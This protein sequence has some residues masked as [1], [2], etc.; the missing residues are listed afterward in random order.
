MQSTDIPLKLPL[1]FAASAGAGYTRVIPTA[2][3]IGVVNGQASLTDG[4]V[5]LNATPIASGGVPPDIKDMN[6]ILFEISG[7]SRWQAAG[8][9]VFYDSAFATAIGGYPKG[10]VLQSATTIGLL[11]VSTAEANT[12]NPDAGGANWTGLVSAPATQAMVNAGVN[13]AAFVT[14]ATLAGLRA[15]SAD[16]IAGTDPAKYMTPQAFYGARA[17]GA[18]VA[19]GVNDH[20]YITPAGLA[21]SNSQGIVRLPGGLVMQY[22]QDNV[23]RAEGLQSMAFN[24]PFAIAVDSVIVCAINDAGGTSGYYDLWVQWDRAGTTLSTF[25]FVVQAP[26]SNTGNIAGTSWVAF[27]R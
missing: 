14:P 1:P 15:T 11:Y 3:Q 26:G 13:N 18:D 21:G 10:A 22:G 2:S 23:L 20:K 19:A 17:S 5:P 27:G 6:G 7:W 12:T 9:P 16:I 25:Q 8:G 24:T 4:F